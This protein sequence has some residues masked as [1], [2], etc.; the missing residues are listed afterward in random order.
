MAYFDSYKKALTSPEKVTRLCIDVSKGE[1]ALTTQIASFINLEELNLE[2]C[3][4]GVNLPNEIAQL[5][6]LKELE[7]KF[8]GETLTIPQ[9]LCN[10]KEF[11]VRQKGKPITIKNII[12]LQSAEEIKLWDCKGNITLP[13]GIDRLPKLKL[14]RVG[15]ENGKS[16][17]GLGFTGVVADA[18]FVALEELS[19]GDCANGFALSKE[20][21]KA[22]V[23]RKLHVSAGDNEKLISLPQTASKLKLTSLEI[24][25]VDVRSCFHYP[26]LVDLDIT[27]GGDITNCFAPMAQHFPK[28][29]V[30]TVFACSLKDKIFPSEIA[31]L[32]NLEELYIVTTML[33]GFPKEMVQIPKLRL[34]SCRNI[35]MKTFP[36]NLTLLSTLEELYFYQQVPFLPESLRNMKALRVLCLEGAL[37]NGAML[38]SWDKTDHIKPLPAIL[39]EMTWLTSLDLNCC[40]VLSLEGLMPLTKL[41]ALELHYAGIKTLEGIETFTEMEELNLDDC[42][43]LKDLKPITRLPKLRTLNIDGTKIEDISAILECKALEE[44]TVSTDIKDLSPI[45]KHPALKKLTIRNDDA[46]A[47]FAR[48]DEL[49]NMGTPDD[50]LAA[51][52]NAIDGSAADAESALKNMN[53]YVEAFSAGDSNAIDTI[54]ANSDYKSDEEEDDED[55]DDYYT[56]KPPELDALLSKHAAQLSSDVLAGVVESTL[57]SITE[58]CY[59]STIPAVRELVRRKDVEAQKRVVQAYMYACGYYDAGHRADEGTVQD[60]L[61]DDW[62]PDFE[63]E[64]LAD[65]LE[66]CRGDHLNTNSGDRMDELFAPAMAKADKATKKRLEEKLVA[67]YSEYLEYYGGEYFNELFKNVE[68]YLSEEA[69]GKFA[70]MDE[71]NKL[72]RDIQDRIATKDPATLE[73]LLEEIGTT[74]PFELFSTFKS[75]FGYTIDGCESLSLSARL[76]YLNIRKHT[77]DSVYSSVTQFI[78]LAENNRSELEQWVASTGTDNE[79]SEWANDVIMYSIEQAAQD[80]KGGELREYLR[81]LYLK[82]NNKISYEKIRE[83]EL[84]NMLAYGMKDDY[85]RSNKIRSEVLYRALNELDKLPN[86]LMVERDSWDDYFTGRLVT[87]VECERYDDA[88]AV[89]YRLPKLIVGKLSLQRILAQAIAL[90]MLKKDTA[91]EKLCLEHLPA[92]VTW[93]ILSY[94]LAC[95]FATKG[96][97]PDLLK[98]AKLSIELGKPSK[99]FMNDSDFDAFKKDPDFLAAIDDSGMERKENEDDDF[100]AFLDSILD[101]ENEE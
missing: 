73:Q 96:N 1:N 15:A 83:K 92:E 47:K 16:I 61:I 70:G 75:D 9:A 58:T 80:G 31:L 37:N 30:L 64:P 78:Y 52:R 55:M 93:D 81:Q 84:C 99:Q 53:A 51:I 35:G 19:L 21:Y 46:M 5:S 29:K 87:M 44:I 98:Y 39:S 97:K 25:K 13:D 100:D 60:Q 57:R 82:H 67:Y 27:S 42:H 36:E 43:S 48:R 85:Q 32:K 6:R 7:I 22:P 62:F 95:L 63:A 94:N 54:F 71:Q 59:T 28:L 77:R 23:L 11:T 40:G 76:Q 12:N 69:K 50:I 2:H 4:E 49:Q 74:I 24:Y 8:E 20:F 41:K 56:S 90:S 34:L 68:P 88:I 66:W 33:V 3:P 14:L 10:V 26:D 72:L 45:Y 86:K 18:P 91:L 65:L 89:V 38:S 79:T 17:T 101:E